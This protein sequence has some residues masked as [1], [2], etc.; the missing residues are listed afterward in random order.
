MALSANT[1][2]EIRSGGSDNNGGG[3]VAGASGVDY[4]QQNAAQFSGTDL[5]IDG[6]LNTKV[7]SASHTFD[8]NDVGNIIQV[9]AGTNFTVGFYQIVSVASGAATLDRAVGT[10]GSTGG[11]WAEGGAMGTPGKVAK[12]CATVAGMI[13]YQRGDGTYTITTS[14]VGADGPIVLATTTDIRWYGYGTVR[15]D[16]GVAT[17]STSVGSITM[18]AQWPFYESGKNQ[19]VANIKCDAN[20]Q[21]NV[22]GF[23]GASQYMGTSTYRNCEAA[24]CLNGFSGSQTT[25][26]QCTA[27]NCTQYGFV[28][29]LADSCICRGCLSGFVATQTHTRWVNCLAY[30]C[31]YGFNNGAYET[32]ILFCTAVDN[33][34]NGFHLG[35]YNIVVIHGCLSAFNGGYGYNMPAADF[36]MRYNASYGNT[37]GAYNLTLTRAFGNIVLSADPFVNRAGNDYRLNDTAGGGADLRAAFIGL[38]GY[39]GYRDIGALQH[40]DSGGGGADPVENLVLATAF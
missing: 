29:C 39:T 12:D 34:V 19:F 27:T 20:G 22:T 1:V 6:T 24:G 30:G 14:T 5:V 31:S 18:F 28:N 21:S 11:T 13:V 23:S 36:P 26:I 17:I 40:E 25:C 9:R 32:H 4:S 35:S 8:A 10:A 33:T 15:G 3:F 37:S 38:P 16:N 7:T 2:W